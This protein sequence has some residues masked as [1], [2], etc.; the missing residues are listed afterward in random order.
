MAWNCCVSPAAIAA[1]AGVTVM[2]SSTAGFTV[3]PASPEIPSFV[4]L[5]VAVPRV[6]PLARP[7][8][9]MLATIVSLLSHTT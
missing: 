4:A 1:L 5:I 8:D 3:S 2:D 6:R 9:V 7:V